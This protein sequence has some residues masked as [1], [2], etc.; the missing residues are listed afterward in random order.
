M[1]RVSSYFTHSRRG[2]MKRSAIRQYG[3]GENWY[4]RDFVVEVPDDVDPAALDDIG[5]GRLADAEG[6][7]WTYHDSYDPIEPSDHEVLGDGV[8]TDGLPVVCCSNTAP[9]DALQ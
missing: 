4:V 1:I 7:Q 6:A 3:F 2:S 5:L 8:P 9:Q